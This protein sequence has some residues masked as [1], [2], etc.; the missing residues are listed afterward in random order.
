MGHIG[1]NYVCG[2]HSP[3]GVSGQVS[4]SARGVNI[5]PELLTWAIQVCIMIV[6]G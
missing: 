6:C 4:L 5:K 3:N 2:Q 1:L